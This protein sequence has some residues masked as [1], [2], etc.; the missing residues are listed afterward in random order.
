MIRAVERVL[1]GIAAAALGWYAT[2]SID[3]AREQ[4]ALS[5]ELETTR[6]AAATAAAAPAVPPAPRAL[7]GRIEIPRVRLSALAREGVDLR[8]LRASAGHVPGTAMPG[9]AGNAAFAAHRDTFFAP[10]KDVRQGDDIVVTTPD[11]DYHYRVTGTRVVDPDAISVL[12]ATPDATL[13]LVTCYP[14]DYIGRA[15]RR[16]IV[17]ARLVSGVE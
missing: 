5:H 12:A 6:T 8:T 11:G 2:V 14:F 13:T 3:A 10:L 16:F 1:F 9:T 7:V 15:P 17:R 4:A